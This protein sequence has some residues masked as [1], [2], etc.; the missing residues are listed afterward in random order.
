MV[1]GRLR[2]AAMV[3]NSSGSEDAAW[4]HGECA[5]AFQRYA[6]GSVC[7]GHRR[8]GVVDVVGSGTGLAAMVPDS[9]GSEDASGGHG[10]CVVA[11][12]RYAS[13]SV[14]HG[15]RRCGVVDVVGSGTGLAAMVPD[16]SGSEDASG[17]HG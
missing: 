4:G 1:G 3:S 8:C 7:H 5:V 13:G 12:Q 9:S 2:M 17:S 15:H 6:S 11:F 16:S 14:C 10:E